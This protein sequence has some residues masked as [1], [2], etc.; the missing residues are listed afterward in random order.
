[1]ELQIEARVEQCKNP[2]GTAG[3]YACS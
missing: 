2:Y 3:A 1:V